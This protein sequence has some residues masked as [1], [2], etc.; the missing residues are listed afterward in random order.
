MKPNLKIIDCN[1]FIGLQIAF[2]HCVIGNYNPSLM[3][4]HFDEF[5]RFNSVWQPYLISPN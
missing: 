3:E 2:E 5:D 1:N 4:N